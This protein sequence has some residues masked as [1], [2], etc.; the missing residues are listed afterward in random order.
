V[1]AAALYALLMA[2]QVGV[3]LTTLISPTLPGLVS[4]LSIQIGATT[5]WIH[6]LAFDLFVGRWIYRD[7]RDREMPAW[8]VSPV[9]LVM[10]LLGPV[11]FLGYCTLR[12]LSAD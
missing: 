7:A 9:L 4:L 11:G 8:L 6:F 2:P 3:V 10:L 12:P 1:P 5:I